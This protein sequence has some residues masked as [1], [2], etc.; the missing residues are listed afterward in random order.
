MLFGDFRVVPLLVGDA[1]PAEVAEA[2]EM[3]WGG[4]ETFVVVSS[5]LSHY[6]GYETARR[7]DRRTADAIEG[8][9]AGEVGP[10]AACGC[11]PIGGLLEVAKKKGLRVTTL[12]LRNSGDTAG[13]RGEVVGY[14]AFSFS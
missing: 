5:D 10:E 6:H 3:V 1:A 12:D 2:I 14:G 11:R 9:R 13:P 8:L 7:I 4:P